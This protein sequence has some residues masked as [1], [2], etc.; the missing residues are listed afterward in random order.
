MIQDAEGRFCKPAGSA[1]VFADHA[2]FVQ[3]TPEG[4]AAL[5]IAQAEDA[6]LGD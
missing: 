2:E 6:K 4:M 3:L 5:A 1:L